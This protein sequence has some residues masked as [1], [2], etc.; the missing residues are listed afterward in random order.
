[1][2]HEPEVGYCRTGRQEGRALAVGTRLPECEGVS[3]SLNR[4][5]QLLVN[6]L[7]R[8]SPGILGGEGQG[9][10]PSREEG[11]N[12]GNHTGRLI[13]AE[14][15]R[16]ERRDRPTDGWDTSGALQG[17]TV[18]LGLL[19]IRERRCRNFQC[20]GDGNRACVSD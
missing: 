10:S 19:G 7:R 11:R 9:M 1:V 15:F 3:R 18:G 2:P 12:A 16:Q 8:R 14:T 20:R 13:Q 5:D 17:C 4:Q 6:Y